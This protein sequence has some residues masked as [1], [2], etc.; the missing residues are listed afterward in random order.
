MEATRESVPDTGR[1]VQ[2]TAPSHRAS[3]VLRPSRH[4]GMIARPGGGSFLF[5]QLRFSPIRSSATLQETEAFVR[6]L[7]NEGLSGLTAEAIRFLRAHEILVASD[8]AEPSP[9]EWSPQRW[10]TVTKGAPFTIRL[11]TC[12]K[13]EAGVR[14]S[15][16][17]LFRWL[18]KDYEGTAG[19]RLRIKFI[20]NGSYH[21]DTLSYIGQ[22]INFITTYATRFEETVFF[23]ELPMRF[24]SMWVD[25]L[26]LAVTPCVSFNV[27]IADA[28]QDADILALEKLV[29]EGFKPHCVFAVSA[30]NQD[31]VR[32][33]ITAL[34]K[35]LG[36]EGYSIALKP[37]SR[38][39]FRSDGI[40]G[41]MLPTSG[42]MTE[43]SALCHS[44]K[45]IEL[46]QSWLYESIRQ[47]TTDTGFVFPCRAC[48]GRALYVDGD[49][50]YFAC[51]KEAATD[52]LRR[53]SEPQA[54][55]RSPDAGY[56]GDSSFSR[57][58]CA[59]CPVRHYCGGL[60]QYSALG[61]A[62]EKVQRRVFQPLCDM[63]MKVILD[64]LEDATKPPDGEVDTERRPRS[65][66]F[67]S[68][69]G[70]L[71]VIEV[72]DDNGDLP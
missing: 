55:L 36:P 26:C 40:Y 28:L 23:L 38:Q 60:C 18:C 54:A 31:Q 15:L 43:L 56:W 34:A 21:K 14:S 10:K 50:M 9:I 46:S 7:R 39:S 4:L 3:S 11:G 12:V 63:R 37:I 72:Y 24:Y 6:K 25:R 68:G 66:R 1:R 59:R 2:A 47:R 62:D 30:V 48:I 65:H 57:S 32:S 58:E 41:E 52:V 45:D 33:D 22:L 71:D 20:W 44:S 35:R 64:F 17:R 13:N 19:P 69:D 51:H 61:V 42:Q 67:I 70:R 29:E 49:G 53:S 8:D 27:D 16:D 5:N